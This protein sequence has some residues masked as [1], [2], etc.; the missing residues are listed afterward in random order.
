MDRSKN[1]ASEIPLVAIGECAC[2]RVIVRPRE[3]PPIW[4]AAGSR[5]HL[6]D[7]TQPGRVELLEHGDQILQ[8]HASLLIRLHVATHER[9][10]IDTVDSLPHGRFRQ[11]AKLLQVE[12]S[13]LCILHTSPLLL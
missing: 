10:I 6:L 5:G 11:G 2:V 13:L 3:R 7:A 4:P 1:R 9:I 8:P 12:Y